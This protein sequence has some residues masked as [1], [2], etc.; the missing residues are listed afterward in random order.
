[1]TPSFLLSSEPSGHSNPHPRA[2]PREKKELA[3]HHQYQI[4]LA[5]L[6]SFSYFSLA[7]LVFSFFHFSVTPKAGFSSYDARYLK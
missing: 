2:T 1:M 5:T 3:I 7:A 4:S 6:Y